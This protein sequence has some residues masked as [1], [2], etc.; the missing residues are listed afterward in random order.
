MKTMGPTLL[1]EPESAALLGMT[2]GGV[3]YI[4]RSGRL[5]A[6]VVGGKR[7]YALDEVEQLKVYRAAHP[8]PRGRPS[9]LQTL[10][11]RAGA[12]QAMEALTR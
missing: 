8:E 1:S 6:R 10:R 9:A 5:S 3:A 2:A 7:H 4:F 11:R 12:V